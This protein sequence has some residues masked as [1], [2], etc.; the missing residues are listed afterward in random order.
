MPLVDSSSAALWDGGEGSLYRDG[1][2]RGYVSEALPAFYGNDHTR[3][4]EVLDIQAGQSIILVGAGFGYVAEQWTGLGYG[5]IVA[6][7]T[8]TWIHANKGDAE[9]LNEDGTTNQSR[10][11]I[12][13]AL[14]LSGNQRATWC[15]SEDMLGVLTDA[16]AVQAATSMRIIGTNVVHWLSCGVRVWNDP[17]TWAGDP[18]LNWKTLEDWKLLLGA[19]TCVSRN[20]NGRVL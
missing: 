3:L 18:R 12:R 5:P 13:Q 9:V 16:E 19:D 7:D 15:I 20:E 8:S 17:N 6:I 2:G 1:F 11:R 14:G 10:G 4:R